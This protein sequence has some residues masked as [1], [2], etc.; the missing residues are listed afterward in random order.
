MPIVNGIN[1]EEYGAGDPVVLLAGTG[2][3][4]RVWR[5]H[6]VPALIKAGFRAITVDNRGIPPS[7]IS[8]E[9]FTLADMVADTIGLIE[10]LRP[11]P[12]R[13][14]GFSMGAIIAQELLTTRSD[15]VS[16][17]VLMATR[18]R[19]DALSAAASHAELELLDSGV[20]LPPRYE[21]VVNVVR[22][23]SRRTLNDERLVRDWLDIFEMSP[24]STM[25]SR[26][27]LSIDTIPNRLERYRTIESACLVMGFTDDLMAP[28]HLAREVAD[29]IPGGTY[30][31][32]AHCG[33]YGQL[34]QP[35]AVNAAILDFFRP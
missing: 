4:G 17:A 2:A 25:L 29:H 21:A 19:T 8:A 6:Q 32:I 9:G 16:Q 11:S 22:G 26:S 15:L 28:P 7:E 13:L 23:F 30:R 3:P 27:Q 20:K 31:E 18:G 33:H 35:E 5:T 1:Y 24:I 14:V 10:H 12:C 34:E